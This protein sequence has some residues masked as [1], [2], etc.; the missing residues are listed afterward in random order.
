MPVNIRRAHEDPWLVEHDVAQASTVIVYVSCS[1]VAGWSTGNGS[2]IECFQYVSKKAYFSELLSKLIP[3]PAAVATGCGKHFGNP[4]SVH[5]VSGEAGTCI[6]GRVCREV[7]D[8]TS[9][10]A[11]KHN[12]GPVL[13]LAFCETQL[14][15][16]GSF[17][18]S[19]GRGS[20]RC[21]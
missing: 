1:L 5:G 6:W 7:G 10:V 16:P 18:L 8:E 17:S 14:W 19:K 13:C 15:W 11:G 2:S 20:K 4:G 21:V 9:E 3:L 12:N